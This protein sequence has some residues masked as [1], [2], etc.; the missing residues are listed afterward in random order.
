M[1]ALCDMDTIQI[2]LTNAC[3]RQC[4]NCTRFVGHRDPYFMDEDVFRTAVNSLI[5]YPKMV[6]FM[7]G[8][9]LLHPR[10]EDYCEYVRERIP[11][12]QLGLWTCLPDSKK[13][14]ARTICDT[15]GHIFIN[16]H[17]RGDIY[18]APILV[19]A[20]EVFKAEERD[21]MFYAIDRCWLQNS[22]SAAI[23]PRGAFF[24]EIAASMSLLFDG[25]WGWPVEPGWWWRTP[26]DFTKQIETYCS[27]C[28]CSLPLP[29]R[30]SVENIDDVSPGNFERLKDISHRIKS[31]RYEISNL[32]LTKQPEQMAAYKD[33]SYRQ[34]ISSRYGMFLL[35]NKLGFLTPIMD[36]DLRREGSIFR[37]LMDAS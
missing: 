29:R 8:E 13:H 31:G 12:N 32:K 30:S 26:K 16:D 6:G 36:L 23:N 14:L 5:G 33:M 22:W 7:G 10:F 2:E 37:E 21:M 28:G 17:T 20:D 1:R 19:A 18:H 11:K 3:V 35:P 24:C 27:K 25:P 9:P 15:F 4:S 34:K